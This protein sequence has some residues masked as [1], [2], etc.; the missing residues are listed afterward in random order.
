MFRVD[1]IRELEERLSLHPELWLPDSLLLLQE[2][3]EHD[4]Q[5]FGIVR[6]EFVGGEFLYALR[7]VSKGAFNLCPSDLCHPGEATPAATEQPEF[8]YFKDIPG[9]AVATGRRIVQAAGLDIGAVEYLESA[10]GRRIFYDINANSNLRRALA[11]EFG[12]DPFERVVDF[13]QREMEDSKS[14][15]ESHEFS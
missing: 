10:D 4:D 15:N 1:H 8:V 13:L 12:F 2:Y 6:M 14:A 5:E 11:P 9:E 7:V 3:V